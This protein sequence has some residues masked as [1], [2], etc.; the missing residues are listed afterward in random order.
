[1]STVQR[2]DVHQFGHSVEMVMASDFDA[3]EARV[4]QLETQVLDLQLQISDNKIESCADAVLLNRLIAE[5]SH[6]R[7]D[8]D[9]IGDILSASIRYAA[10]YLD[11]HKA[12]R[13]RILELAEAYDDREDPN[14]ALSNLRD[15][16]VTAVK[17][18]TKDTLN[19]II[20]DQ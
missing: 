5:N 11:D 9:V 20:K 19:I 16:L 4:K 2:Y 14:T 3:S 7:S 12:F 15:A 17:Q 18:D 1:M 13:K 10:R 8:I 6:L